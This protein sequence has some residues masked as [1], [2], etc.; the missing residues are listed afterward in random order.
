MAPPA[1]IP[2]TSSRSHQASPG[3]RESMSANAAQSL[4][5]SILAPPPA[6]RARTIHNPEDPP[7]PA[8]A[9]EC[10]NVAVSETENV[11]PTLKEPG[12]THYRA[13]LPNLSLTPVL[14]NTHV[15]TLERARI[16]SAKTRKVEKPAINIVTPTRQM[17]KVLTMWTLT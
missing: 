12:G 7:V 14:R 4:Y 15:P 8:P 11:R 5:A 16:P 6:K 13:Q 17:S 9:E 1:T 10:T 3:K 2:S